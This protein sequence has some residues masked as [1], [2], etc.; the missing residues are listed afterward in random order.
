LEGGVLGETRA[1]RVGQRTRTVGE[2]WLAWIPNEMGQLFDAARKELE[3]SNLILNITLN[4]A[5]QLCKD[6]QRE[7]AG[8][9]VEVFAGLFDRLAARVIHVIGTIHGHAA[10]FGTLPNV[11]PLSASNFRGAAAQRISRTDSLLGKVVFGQ[12]SR[13]FHKLYAVDEIV[14]ELQKEMRAVIAGVDEED[15]AVRD[16]TWNL[17]EVLSYDMSTCMEETTI[18]LK[19]FFCALPPGELGAFR[20]KLVGRNPWLL[21]LDPQGNPAF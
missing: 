19:S 17:L 13:F 4:D 15:A 18:L 5:L 7:T 21:G 12:R 6:G 20:E 3:S 2:D 8:E 10:H 9:R 1:K 16:I 14:G 11:D